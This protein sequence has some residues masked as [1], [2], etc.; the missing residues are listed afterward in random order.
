MGKY[1]HIFKNYE[2]SYLPGCPVIIMGRALVKE[3]YTGDIYAQVKFQNIGG[4]S[5]AG[6]SASVT[7][8]DVYGKELGSIKN[9]QYRNLDEGCGNEFGSKTLIPLDT[10]ARGFEVRLDEVR[11]ADGS[12][13]EFRNGSWEKLPEQELIADRLGKELAEEYCR[14]T[15]RASRYVPCKNEDIWLCSCGAVNMADEDSCRTCGQKYSELTEALDEEKLKK[16][17]EEKARK[18]KIEDDEKH[19]AERKKE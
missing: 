14:E 18:K 5:V 11:F 19:A 3:E 16:A 10:N 9:F 7:V 13:L 17:Y 2:G 6:I 12:A 15:S 1:A 8:F 4:K